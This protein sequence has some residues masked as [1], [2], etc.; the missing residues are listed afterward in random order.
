[1]KTGDW[2]WLAILGCVIALFLSPVSRNVI[3]AMG[4]GHPLLTGFLK[5]AVLASMG[6]LLAIRIVSGEWRAPAGMPYRVFVWGTVGVLVVV[7]FAVFTAGVDQ[8]VRGGLLPVSPNALSSLT[9]AAWTSIALN[10]AFAPFLM[11]GH[12]MADTYL[13]L[14]EGSIVKLRSVR[15]EQV[16]SRIDWQGLIRFVCLRTI[17]LF[18]LPAHVI[19]FLLPLEYRV[20]YAA[21]LSVLLGVILAF[22][23]R[24]RQLS[25]ND[26]RYSFAGVDIGR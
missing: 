1:L 8:A 24:G 7:S 16:I 3:A 19:T 4:S 26:N 13:D 22:S 17:P 14:A 18:W 12:R 10:S 11:I 20:I 2:I 15:V 23:K 9:K 25:H 6:E 21:F 5:F